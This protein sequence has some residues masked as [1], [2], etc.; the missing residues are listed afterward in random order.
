MLNTGSE[1]GSICPKLPR[2]LSCTTSLE[3]E[4]T[5]PVGRSFNDLSIES[6]SLDVKVGGIF[7][8]LEAAEIPS[9]RNSAEVA[10]YLIHPVN[11]CIDLQDIHRTISIDRFLFYIPQF[12]AL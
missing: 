6:L 1:D 12:V 4:T 7:R 5:R 11:D 8:S 10:R 9:R 2:V 3:P